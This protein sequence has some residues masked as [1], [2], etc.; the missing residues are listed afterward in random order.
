MISASSKKLTRKGQGR[1]SR[2][3]SGGI[4]YDPGYICIEIELIM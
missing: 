1:R 4:I 2:D 3:E